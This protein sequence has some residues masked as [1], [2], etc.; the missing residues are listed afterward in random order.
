MFKKILFL[1]VFTLAASGLHAQEN[2]FGVKGGVS[3][4]K[5]SGGSDHELSR[6]YKSRVA[7]DAGAF[8]EFGISR[9]FSVQPEINFSGNGGKRK[10]VQP[11]TS[12][13]P[14]LPPLPEGVYYYAEFEN[15]AVLNYLEI[16]VLVKYRFNPQSK[17]RV[18]VNGG[19]FYGR[20]LSAKTKTSGTSTIYLDKDKTPLLI[21]PAFQ[22]LPAIPFDAETDIKSQVNKNNFGLTGG[23]GIEFKH[24]KNYFFVDGRITY[25]LRSI[26][27]DPRRNGDSRSGGLIFSA[28]YAFGLK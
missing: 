17:K 14:G 5:L 24:G 3:L 20:L 16:P 18:Y 27:K 6:D 19:V 13:V 26:Q 28:G 8:F 22:T 25:G 11:I 10:G 23:G 2:Y 12:A 21:P 9:K 4:P 7:L 15:E 1:F